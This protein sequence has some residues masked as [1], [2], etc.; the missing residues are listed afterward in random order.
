MASKDKKHLTGINKEGRLHKDDPKSFQNGGSTIKSE[1]S[2]P[3]LRSLAGLTTFPHFMTV[4]RSEH[5]VG[6]AVDM[7]SQKM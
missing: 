7:P 5:W 4:K 2:H 1:T 6:K 3:I